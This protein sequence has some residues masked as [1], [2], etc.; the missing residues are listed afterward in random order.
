MLA[1]PAGETI[2]V[3]LMK[4]FYGE[5]SAADGLGATPFPQ[6]PK[7]TLGTF[8]GV[9]LGHQRVLRELVTWAHDTRTRSL[10][11]TFDRK[12][13][14]VLAGKPA[15]QI[16]S[17][18]HRLLLFERLG[19]DAA[20]V[21]TFD[22]DLAAQEAETFV[23][24][25]LLERLHVSGVLLGHDTRF[26]RGARGDVRLLHQLGREMG[27]ETRSVPVVKLDGLPVSSTRLRH[28]TRTGDLRVAERMLGRRVS[29]LGSVVG[30][31]G[32]GKNIGFPTA[33]LD[34]HHETRP[35]EGVYATRSSV[36]GVWHDSVTNI[37][38]APTVQTPDS[39]DGEA[40]AVVETHLLD[41]SGDLYGK[42][43]EVQFVERLRS[44]QMFDSSA[45]LAERIAADIAAARSILTAAEETGK[46]SG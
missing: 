45:A 40:E 3:I 29:V 21:L 25:L 27:F 2:G 10:V 20:L 8:D 9:H 13:R 11:L 34:L 19:I 14:D 31:T 30:G 35:P 18:S 43:I 6:R 12:P 33:N 17:L 36:D 42:D 1:R 4:V 39:T 26:G 41:F 23:R 37:G 38:R 7:A 15:E 24:N 28:A 32:R 22:E 46:P 16:I 5:A 44:E